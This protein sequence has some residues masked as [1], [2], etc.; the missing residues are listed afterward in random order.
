MT[1]RERSL[2]PYR[3]ALAPAGRK[4]LV[5][6]RYAL[7][8]LFD[9]RLFLA[10]FLVCHVPT[11]ALA[12]ILYAYA[13]ADL[14]APFLAIS[15]IAAELEARL[16]AAS[17]SISLWVSF[18]VVL[19][20][21]P[22]LVAPDFANNAMQL[23]LCRGLRKRDYVLGKLLALLLVAGPATWVPGAL[24]VLLAAEPALHRSLLEGVRL[25]LA[26]A[27]TTL[28]WTGCLA[29]IVFALAAWVKTRPAATL[30]FL[31]LFIV[32]DVT[33]DLLDAIFGGWLGGV[34]DL[35]DAIDVVGHALYG[36]AAAPDQSAPP[37]WAAWAALLLGTGIAAAAL[38]RRLGARELAT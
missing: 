24:L 20:A 10:F 25:A 22:A 3:G 36:M 30:G 6:A 7:G 37:A 23:V 15:E 4:P 29:M 33:G 2:R 9:S 12:G 16:L 13:N 19:V 27:T 34:L 5:I 21:G 38:A 31:G 8:R 17:L 1:A 28:A 26:L 35:T 32:A 11:L 14:V 18:L